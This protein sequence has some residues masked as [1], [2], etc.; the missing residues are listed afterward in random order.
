MRF[1]DV[2]FC[3]GCHD[4]VVGCLGKDSLLWICNW[5]VVG[6]SERAREAGGC[7][8]GV[9]GCSVGCG[10]GSLGGCTDRPLCDG[11]PEGCEGW[12]ASLWCEV[13]VWGKSYS[14]VVDARALFKDGFWLFG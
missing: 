1:I 4:L 14:L 5:S 11:C 2:V 13:S 6:A 10:G 8:T 3:N 12:G 7:C 9:Q